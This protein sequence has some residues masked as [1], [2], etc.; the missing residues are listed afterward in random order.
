MVDYSKIIKGLL[1]AEAII[2]ICVIMLYFSSISFVS[3]FQPIT[4]VVFNQNTILDIKEATIFGK[5]KLGPAFPEENMIFHLTVAKKLSPLVVIKPLIYTQVGNNPEQLFAK[6]KNQSLDSNS[7]QT[8]DYDFFSQNEG[9][10]NIRVALKLTYPYVNGSG[11]DYINGTTS[12]NVI[13]TSDK[14]L[15]DQ[16]NTIFWGLIISGISG[17]GALIFTAYQTYSSKQER[18]QTVRAWI[19]QK[20]ATLIDL[21]GIYNAQNQ[22]LTSEQWSQMTTVQQNA[23]TPT[24]VEYVLILKNYGRIPAFNVQGRLVVTTNPSFSEMGG[25]YGEPAEIMPDDEHLYPIIIPWQ[26]VYQ[27][28]QNPNFKFYILFEVKYNSGNMKKKKVYGFMS[29]FSSNGKLEKIDSWDEKRK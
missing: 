5:Y 26:Y 24:S 14:L 12:F 25:E 1:I 2:V 29:E 27:K 15:S 4:S 17:M 3:Q 7:Y 22:M 20:G 9:E 21:R 18:E 28:Q 23:F 10:N 8:F 16:N 11:V 19:G 6:N 13:S